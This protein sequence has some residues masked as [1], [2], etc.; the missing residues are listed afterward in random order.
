MSTTNSIRFGNN[1]FVNADATMTYS[2]FNSSYPVARI[3]DPRRSI[4][5]LFRGNF[6]IDATNNKIYIN[7][8][9][10]KTITLTSAE[11]TGA[12]LATHIQTQLNASSSNWTCSYS[13]TTYK[14]TINRTSGTGVLKFTTTTTA[15]WDT[16]GYT[17]AVDTNVP[18][19]SDE[20][21]IHTHEY[22]VLDLG[23]SQTIGFVG[24]VGPIDEEFGFSS[25][26][27][28]KI[29][30]NNTN[31][32]TSP[33]T[34]VTLTRDSS[35]AFAFP[36]TSHRY[37]RLYFEDRENASGPTALK[38]GYISISTAL[39]YAVTSIA[40]GFSVE[41]VDNSSV[42]AS[43][44]GTKYFDTRP[45]YWTLSGGIGLVSGTEMTDLQ[46][47]FFDTGI[48]EP[49]F[50]SIDPSL[51]VFSYHRDVTKLVRFSSVP[52]LTHVIRDVFNASI[53][54]EELT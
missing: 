32:W 48:T 38:I 23:T 40:N 31:T 3:Y 13:S 24:V 21:R 14:F 30:G 34:N 7:D 42:I 16:L 46:Q 50:I 10:D 39:T 37:W 54:V 29:Q 11:Y 47:F 36:D 49:F 22:I 4:Y 6:L 12:T 26:S 45:V 27:T 15:A 5:S 18:V 17:T 35:G 9:G 25:Y 44:N 19:T 20:S 1:N 41:Y 43:E 53:E 28:I 8:G 2:T 51:S 33:T 52:T